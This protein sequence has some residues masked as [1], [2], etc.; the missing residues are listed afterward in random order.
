MIW[1]LRGTWF[2]RTRRSS[3]NAMMRSARLISGFRWIPRYAEDWDAYASNSC[4]K[5]FEVH[6]SEHMEGKQF[7]HKAGRP[8]EILLWRERSDD[9]LEARVAPQRV[10]Q[11]VKTQVTVGHMAPW[12]F[13]CFRQSFNCAVLV[14]SPRINDS[15][16]LD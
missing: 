12:Q 7:P 2:W 11:R 1:L 4:S 10:P 5:L 9:C 16:I 14:A 6:Y 13:G 15:Q 8:C 3:I